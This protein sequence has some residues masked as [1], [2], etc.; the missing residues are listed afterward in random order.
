M[1][2]PSHGVAGVLSRF[3]HGT[4]TNTAISICWPSIPWAWFHDLIMFQDCDSHCLYRS[5]LVASDSFWRQR[6]M[7]ARIWDSATK[8]TY[9]TG[10]RY[11]ASASHA[12][13]QT[14]YCLHVVVCPLNIC[15]LPLYTL[16]A[17]FLHRAQ[18]DPFPLIDVACDRDCASYVH[19]GAS[20]GLSLRMGKRQLSLFSSGGVHLQGYGIVVFLLRGF[21]RGFFVV[22]FFFFFSSFFLSVL[23]S[24]LHRSSRSVF[25][26]SSSFSIAVGA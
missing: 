12:P 22:F 16:F 13:L 25:C 23:L 21:F 8:K 20:W 24:L 26:S 18:R 5:K 17:A 7:S 15:I 9:V 6:I 11:P 2:G 19:S 1:Q 10:I 4:S 14:A 3:C